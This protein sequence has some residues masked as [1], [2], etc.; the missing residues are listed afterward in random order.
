M[1][2][3]YSAYPYVIWMVI[4]TVVPLL[5]VAAFAITD[6]SG[7]YTLENI[8]AVGEYTPVLMRS[9]WLAAIATVLCLVIAYPLAYIL[10]RKTGSQQRTM[11]ML[12]MLPTWMNFLL[13]TYAWMT[14]LEKNGIINRLLGF[15]G[16]GP[17]DM[18]NTQGAVVLIFWTNWES[19][20]R[21]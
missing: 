9:I 5:L 8:S 7:A 3:R 17:F 11:L 2:S 13:R 21:E 19:N 10:S 15:I 18:I 16:L 1:K 20:I 12:V 14:L 4:F 6:S